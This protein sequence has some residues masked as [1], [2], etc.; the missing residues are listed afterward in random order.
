[1]RASALEANNPIRNSP[2]NSLNNPAFMVPPL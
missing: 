1:M 2:L